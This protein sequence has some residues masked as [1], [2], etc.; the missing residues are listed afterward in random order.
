MFAPHLLVLEFCLLLG[1]FFLF[2]NFLE[3]RKKKSEATP[4]TLV[5]KFRE[6]KQ[7]AEE[8]LDEAEQT[9]RDAQRDRN[10]LLK[11]VDVEE[12]EVVEEPP[13]SVAPSVPAKAVAPKPSPAKSK[14]SK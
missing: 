12:D 9:I 11:L 3:K 13:A 6:V 8:A 10:D 5:R 14:P 2:K 7:E 1:A 4:K